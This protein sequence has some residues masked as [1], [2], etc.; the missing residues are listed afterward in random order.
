MHWLNSLRIEDTPTPNAEALSRQRPTVPISTDARRPNRT[1]KF[2]SPS[3]FLTEVAWWA[4]CL[5]SLLA[6]TIRSTDDPLG[7]ALA[8]GGG[9]EEAGGLRDRLAWNVKTCAGSALIWPLHVGTIDYTG[10]PGCLLV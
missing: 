7:Q 3:H 1:A 8:V 9:T 6:T 2:G 5:N 10:R 4:S